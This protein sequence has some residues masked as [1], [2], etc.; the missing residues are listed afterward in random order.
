MK[1]LNVNGFTIIEALVAIIVI[2]LIALGAFSAFPL[3]QRFLI[4]SELSLIAVNFASETMEE[5][6]WDLN[7]LSRNPGIDPTN[8]LP[9]NDP[10]TPANVDEGRLVQNYGGVTPATNRVIQTI[11]NNDYRIINVEVQYHY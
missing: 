3:A 4:R 11:D 7:T 6:Y 9:N 1:R 8:V 2:A 5:L 10:A